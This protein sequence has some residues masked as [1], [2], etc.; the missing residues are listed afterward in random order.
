ME[1]YTKRL[2]ALSPEQRELFELRRKKQMQKHLKPRIHPVSREQRQFPLSFSQQRL[3]FL[4]QLEASSPA[5]NEPVALHLRGPLHRQALHQ[6]LNEIVSR[7]EIF[8][9]TF[10]AID[11]LPVQVVTPAL[12]LPL[13]LIDLREMAERERWHEAQR[14]I[15]QEAQ[16]LFELAQ[17]PAIRATLLCLADDEHVLLLTTHHIAS[18][19]WSKGIFM[20]ELTA[21]YAAFAT[22]QPSPL[23]ALPVQYVDYAVWQREWLQGAVLEASLA[24]WKQQLAGMP[25]VLELPTDHPRPPMQSFHGAVYTFVLPRTLIEALNAFGQRE[26]AT[27]FMVLLAAF[28]TLLFRY[29]G[30]EDVVVASP[31]A[32]RTRTETEEL[33]GLFA[34]ML[35]LRTDLAGNP[36]FKELVRRVRTVTLGAFEYQDVPFDR[37]ITELQYS[38]DT[39]YNPL[40]QILFQLQNIPLPEPELVGLTLR[41]LVI[42]N[43]TAKFDLSIMLEETRQ[44][45]VGTIEYNADLFEAR[46][47]YRMCGH[48][49]RLLEEAVARPECSITDFSLL[50]F[51]EQRQILN[52]WNATSTDYPEDLCLHHLF[53]RQVMQH[54]EA[55][56]VI[57][58][59]EQVSYRELNVRANKLAHH[60]QAWGVG[61][62]VCVGLCAVRSFDLVVG[63]LGIV[64][65]GGAYLPL[66]PTYPASRLAL[67]L[68]DAQ[69]PVLLTQQGLLAHLPQSAACLFCLDVDW[70]SLAEQPESDPESQVTPEHLVYLIYTS[71]STGRPKGVLLNHRGRVNNFTDFN[72]R[73]A[74]G[75]QDRVL[76]ISSPSFDMC[77]YDTFGILASGGT[78]VLPEAALE[79]DPAHWAA[80]MMRHQ[81]TIWHSVPALLELLYEYMNGQQGVS[82]DALR[83]V[84]LG[85]DWIPVTLP[86]RM[87]MLVP[88]LEV[89]SLGG[90]TEA[91]MDSTIYAVETIDPAWRSIP[92][93]RPMANQTCY[94]LDAHQQPVPVGVPGELHLGG[95]GLAWGYLHCPD[96][97]AQKFVPHPF[98]ERPGD[99]L[100][101]TG[102]LAR[103]QQDGSL[104]L[105]GRVDFQ[106][107]LHGLRIETG[108]IEVAL[109]QLSAVQEAMVLARTDAA[110]H[111]R[112]VAY[113]VPAAGYQVD[114]H[115]LK[116]DLHQTLPAYMV[117]T[118]F[119]PLTAFPLT[120]N[121]K[122]DRRNL[123][124]PDLEIREQT[125]YVAPRTHV[126]RILA[127][128]WEQTLG[129]EHVGIHDSFFAQGGDSILCIQVMAR[130][131]QHGLHFTPKQLFQYQTI[132]ELSHAVDVAECV[133]AEQDLV[134][135]QVPLTPRQHWLF[136]D[137]SPAFPVET[138]AW[139]VELPQQA[140]RSALTRALYDVLLHHDVLRTRFVRKASTWQQCQDG[141]EGLE[142]LTVVDLSSYPAELRDDA[143]A[144][145]V[146]EV[147]AV[148]YQASGQLARFVYFHYGTGQSDR[149]LLLVH[150]LLVDEISWHILLR[151]IQQVY[152]QLVQGEP[153]RLAAKTISLKHWSIQAGR[154]AQREQLR[155]AGAVWLTEHRQ[156]VS[157]LPVDY[158]SGRN[159]QATT[160]TLTVSIDAETSLELLQK[161]P[162]VY[163]IQVRDVLVT[164]C[165]LTF[166]RWTGLPSLYLG[167]E[168]AGR[169]E[170]TQGLDVTRTLG[171]FATWCPLWLTGEQ[172]EA[173]TEHDRALK[174]VKEQL[175]ALPAGGAGYGLLRYLSPESEVGVQMSQLPVPELAFAY[176]E[177]V[178]AEPGDLT[179]FGNVTELEDVDELESATREVHPRRFLIEVHVKNFAGQFHVVWRYSA[180]MHQQA[181]IARLAGE[182]GTILRRLVAHCLAHKAGGYT[183][184]DFRAARLNQAQLDRFMAR[185][186]S[187]EGK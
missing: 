150:L 89:I 181:T 54:P 94:V 158:P 132:A 105:L 147:R 48:Y 182:Y 57:Y 62:G 85:G 179:L 69:V 80:L 178:A 114:E 140:D 87:R 116:R 111:K 160:R 163:R 108:E 102:D 138:R 95:V 47:I 126:E 70:P 60:L 177:S 115:D 113:V 141:L 23:A 165:Y 99:R 21:L 10:Q 34:N 5:Y 81:V 33:I 63:L 82:L 61:P 169:Q 184:A 13:P 157:S 152:R 97:T 172:W 35:I 133:Q 55:A 142:P 183:P 144:R 72:R 39:S 93:G 130:A 74:V 37:L 56:A 124:A 19:G 86:E 136:T 41:S 112:L 122:V 100:Y 121:G 8:R 186:A 125:A 101:R 7:H 59:D 145:S 49:Q 68:E 65:A 173:A 161:V 176:H 155:K 164:A 119:V 88:E 26:D 118:L 44:G 30:Q 131:G 98:S 15:L 128:I 6:S 110:G 42:D 51:V 28:Q 9:T 174:C 168:I 83:L 106:V 120:P 27:L 12:H 153:A 45:L 159:L 187:Q 22:A 166:A 18:D 96:L 53:T 154:S 139:L 58:R 76:A 73:F 109:K 43:H 129:V 134:T 67:M 29:S 103:Y 162:E 50:T 143:L 170:L 14:L 32:N 36:S 185:L 137:T 20:R 64:K 117:P 148:M 84:L 79:R 40:F 77:A 52:E 156:P 149:L 3:W 2:S 104:E 16:Q 171:P 92:Y 91:S 78:I 151:D 175:H 1:E 4:D 24:Y 31:V 25:P 17:R 167:L 71:G 11:G 135:G 127:Q 66:D 46:T 107:K 38:R 180:A 146:R 123:P 75:V 90:A